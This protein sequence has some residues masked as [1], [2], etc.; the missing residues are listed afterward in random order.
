MSLTVEADGRGRVSLGR[1]L[2]AGTYRATQRPDGSVLLEPAVV[3]SRAELALHRNT[4]VTDRIDR[5]AAG[6][7]SGTTEYTPRARR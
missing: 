3:L 5:I 1:M 4:A 6:D 2:E 7:L